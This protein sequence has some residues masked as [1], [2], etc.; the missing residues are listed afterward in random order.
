MDLEVIGGADGPTSVFVA[1]QIGDDW[2][3]MFGLIIVVLMLLPN[4]I[5]AIKYRGEENRCTNKVMN[6]LEQIGRYGSMLLMIVCIDFGFP[7]VGNFLIYLFG[8]GA[9]LLAYWCIWILF[10]IKRRMWKSMALAV[11]PTMIFLLSGITLVYVPLMIS[12]IV[13]G[14]AHCYVTYQ[15]AK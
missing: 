15:N 4:I 9:L 11:I 8:N 10:F 1:G 12:S 6:V 3:N 14:V 7:S 5:Y 2:F 13:F